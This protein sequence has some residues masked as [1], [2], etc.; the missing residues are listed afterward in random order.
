ME[1]SLEGDVMNLLKNT[2]KKGLTPIIATVLLLMLTI[3]AFGMAYVWLSKMQNNTQ[4]TISNQVS[5]VAGQLGNYLNIISVYKDTSGNT[6][7]VVK[8]TGNAAIS[9]NMLGNATLLIDGVPVQVTHPSGGLDPYATAKYITISYPFS[10]LTD[11]KMHTIKL[12]ISGT[13]LSEV[14]CGPLSSGATA[15]NI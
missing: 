2:K 12:V 14:H 5:Q 13:A 7:V 6:V 4:N 1:I 3:V 15:C 11:Q 8:N 10:K 9:A